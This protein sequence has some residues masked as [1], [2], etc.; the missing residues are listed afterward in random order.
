MKTSSTLVCGPKGAGKS[1]FAH[2]L[3]NTLL[4][5]PHLRKDGDETFPCIAFL[6][7]DPGQPHFTP[8]GHISLVILNQ[9]FF[10]PPYT[11]PGFPPNKGAYA[12]SRVLRS[13]FVAATTPKHDHG[14]FDGCIRD[15]VA[16]Y[17]QFA[18][19]CNACPLVINCPGWIQGPGFEFMK[20]TV[21]LIVPDQIVYMSQDGPQRVLDGIQRAA[22]RAKLYVLPSQE[23]QIKGRTALDLRT[24]QTMSYFHLSDH[25]SEHLLWKS[26][27]M[28]NDTSWNFKYAGT[29]RGIFGI[30]IADENS[31]ASQLRGLLDGSLVGVVVLDDG[32]ALDSDPEAEYTHMNIRG[33]ARADREVQCQNGSLNGISSKDQ[34][35]EEPFESQLQPTK[36]GLPYIP[37]PLPVP[38][39]SHCIGLGYVRK[40]DTSTQVMDI[41]TPI[42]KSYIGHLKDQKIRVILILGRLDTPGWA[43]AEEA[44]ES[45]FWWRRRMRAGNWGAQATSQE[46]TGEK[47]RIT[48]LVERSPWLKERSKKEKRPGEGPWKVRRNL[49][50]R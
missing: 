2:L 12:K 43:Y 49:V 7:L 14:H 4:T 1:T 3:A 39:K 24:M 23:S 22:G 48:D 40:I 33:H 16:R 20:R 10:G 42:S 25:R 41:V 36:E 13:H 34:D 37:G 11:H 28:A 27:P 19:T 21:R 15:L 35:L 8:S 47:K 29:N 32:S 18:S 30:M 9:P 31:Q 26:D 44:I 46:F 45:H 5:R 6:D 50:L 17:S 38:S